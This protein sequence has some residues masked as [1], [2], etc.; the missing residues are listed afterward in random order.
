MRYVVW[1]GHRS[2]DSTSSNRHTIHVTI[3][4]N[5]RRHR[6]HRTYFPIL[7]SV[8]LDF[9]GCTKLIRLDA[10]GAR[11]HTHTQISFRQRKNAINFHVKTSPQS[12]DGIAFIRERRHHFPSPTNTH[13]LALTHTPTF[14][15]RVQVLAPLIDMG[16]GLG[17]RVHNELPS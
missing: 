8:F 11:T 3:R 15:Q 7:F 5:G 6:A 16:G 13:P 17:V 9:R 4:Q 10:G 12:G 1:H 2:T 14:W